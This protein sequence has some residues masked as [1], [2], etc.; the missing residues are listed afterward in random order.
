M[1]FVDY[2]LF[3]PSLVMLRFYARERENFVKMLYFING[4]VT[5]SYV[6]NALI[7]GEIEN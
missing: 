5:C 6:I 2:M 4:Y 1:K 3:V 7:K